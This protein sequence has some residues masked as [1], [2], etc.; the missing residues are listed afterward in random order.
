MKEITTLEG[1]REWVKHPKQKL[2]P[3]AVRGINIDDCKDALM[4]K[5]TEDSLFL[6]CE[7][8]DKLAGH[9]VKTGGM[10][11]PNGNDLHFRSHLTQLYSPEQLFEGFDPQHPNGYHLTMDYKVYKQYVSQG[12]DYP[13]G[14]HISLMRRLH[15]H[16]ITEALW[17]AIEGKKIVAIMGGHGMERADPMYLQ[18]AKISRTLTQKGFLL[19]SGGG[20]GAMEATHVGAHFAVRP[21]TDMI[22]GINL[23]KKRPEGAP[24]GKEYDDPCWLS[25]GWAVRAAYPIPK[26]KEAECMSIGIPTWHYGHEPP[27]VFATHIAKYFAN[28]VREE[29]LLAIAKHGVIFAPGS[30]GTTQ[31]IFQ[32]ACQ[33]HYYAY[34]KDKEAVRFVSPMILFGTEHWTQKIPVW[35]LLR[36]V[37][38]GRPYGELL[39]LTDDADEVIQRI[40]NYKPEDYTFPE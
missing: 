36:Q 1:L 19:V 37:S 20:P 30:A 5:V 24:T 9:I 29:G 33:N 2:S 3:R 38:S 23:M 10:V 34:N 25:R 16:A 32:D 11:I 35:D 8:C 39:A 6:G 26:G 13:K 15:D 21:E 31:E 14:I 22:A 7:M 27:A 4:L 17:D 18:I 12:K 28:S 40:L